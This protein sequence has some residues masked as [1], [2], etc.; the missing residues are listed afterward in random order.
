M[1]TN[2]VFNVEMRLRQNDRLDKLIF[3]A[4]YSCFPAAACVNQMYTTGGAS[5]HMA[6]LS[7]FC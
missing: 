5:E 2:L 7:L 6:Y 3:P 1:L 4:F